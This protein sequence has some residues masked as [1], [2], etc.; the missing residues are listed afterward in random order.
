MTSPLNSPLETAIRVLTILVE[1]FLSR[2][3]INRLVLLDHGLLHS[4]DLGGPASLHPP[5]PSRAGEL[6]VKRQRI[7]LGIEVLV[8]AGL[9]HMEPRRDGIQFWAADGAKSFIGLFETD[10]AYALAARAAWVVSQFGALT[11]GD[12]RQ[13]M[14]RA[15]GHWAEEFEHI[16]ATAGNG[17]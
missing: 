16:Q 8:R 13:A 11:D 1:A 7:Q 17:A 9:A 6:G 5:V 2:L 10:Y 14:R 15:A 4:A 3:D 12:L